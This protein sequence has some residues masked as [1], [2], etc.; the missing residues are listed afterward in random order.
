MP[1]PGS[2][3]TLTLQ[4]RTTCLFLSPSTNRKKKKK[5]VGRGEARE[6]NGARLL[7]SFICYLGNLILVPG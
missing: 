4:L 6:E 3:T 5:V 1:A 2:L 7:V